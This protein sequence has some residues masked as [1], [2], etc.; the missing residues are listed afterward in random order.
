MPRAVKS[1]EAGSR[2]AMI[3]TRDP[4]ASIPARSVGRSFVSAF[5]VKDNFII[6]GDYCLNWGNANHFYLRYVDHGFIQW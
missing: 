6:D 1:P 5:N 4:T 2:G 3:V